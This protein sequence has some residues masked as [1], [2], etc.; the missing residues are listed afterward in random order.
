MQSSFDWRVRLPEHPEQAD[1]ELVGARLCLYPE[2]VVAHVMYR[3]RGHPVSLWKAGF[4]SYAEQPLPAP[5]HAVSDQPRALLAGNKLVPPTLVT[6]GD[7]AGH[8]TPYPASPLLA[9]IGIP[10]WK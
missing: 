7:E 6:D 10:C 4:F 9:V 8:S 2:G 5:L 3:H 1:L